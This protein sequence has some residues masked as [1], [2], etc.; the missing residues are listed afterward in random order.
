VEWLLNR[1]CLNAGPQ[2]LHACYLDLLARKDMATYSGRVRVKKLLGAFTN[3]YRPE[4]L[5]KLGC[6]LDLGSDHNWL[7]RL[8]RSPRMAQ[9]PVSQMLFVR[10]LGL[11]AETFFSSLDPLP[12]FGT[13]PWPCLN[14]AADHYG[15]RHITQC[16]VTFTKDHGRPVG[17]FAC[18]CGFTY[19][20]SGPDSLPEDTPL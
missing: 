16:K 11:T 20:R 4:F 12:P 2:S 8:V 13:G 7:L 19:T 3:F 17:L 5:N 9:P 18:T 10:F 14:G 6:S 15:Q 1:G